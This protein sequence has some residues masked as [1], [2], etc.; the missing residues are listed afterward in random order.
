[1]K[2]IAEFMMEACFLKHMPRSGYQYLGTG[3]ESV[4][5][6]VYAATMFAYVLAQLTPGV[7]LQRLVTMCL[8]HD[9]PET[10]VGDLNYVQKQ[11]VEADETKALADTLLELPFKHDI[12]AV[13]REFNA[14]ETLE[15]RLAHD[16]DQLALIMDLKYLKDIGHQPPDTW[17]P[18]VKERLKTDIAI[19]LAQEILSQPWD[20]WWRKIFC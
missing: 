10:R 3:R 13:L 20:G 11:Y 17:L 1:M 2:R 6:H 7:N 12:E 14:G 15:S 5:E 16:A 19:Q 9:L 4:A 18:H 8:L